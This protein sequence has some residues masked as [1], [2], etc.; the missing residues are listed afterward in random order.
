MTQI[1]FK[2]DLDISI[3]VAVHLVDPVFASRQK[4]AKSMSCL[5][6]LQSYCLY[7]S[8]SHFTQYANYGKSLRV[9][10]KPVSL[11]KIPCVDFD[12]GTFHLFF[13]DKPNTYMTVVI[14]PDLLDC[15]K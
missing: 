15:W 7:T 13:C 8:T 11:Y 2:A 3:I 6:V 4:I 14:F 9:D 5:D 12:S 10:G 1:G